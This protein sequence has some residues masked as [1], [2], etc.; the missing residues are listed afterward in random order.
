MANGGVV[1]PEKSGM[2]VIARLLLGLLADLVLD[3]VTSGRNSFSQEMN[4]YL[5]RR[6]LTR[7]SATHK[8]PAR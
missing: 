5:E 6:G 8:V 4:G 7:D 1:H 3:S 2:T